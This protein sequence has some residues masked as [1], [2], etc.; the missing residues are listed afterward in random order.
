MQKYDVVI[1]GSGIG[2]LC[3]G[4]I[5]ALSG[6]KVLICEA[7][8]KPGGV[9]HSFNK[10]GY[11]FESGPSLW[12]GISKWPTTNPLGQIL[13]LLDVEVELFKYKGWKVIVPE[14]NFDLDVGEEPFKQIVKNLRGEQSVK[15]W[16]SFISEIQPLSQI[17]NEIPLL[18]FSPE[19]TN[20]LDLLNLTSKI[21]PNIKQIP[22]INKG[23][24][25][26]VNKHLEDPFLRNWVDLLS[27]LISGMSMHDTNTAAMATL[28]NEWFEPNSYLEY[29]KG[30]SESIV[31]ALINGLKKNGGELIL[32]SKVKEINFN[33]NL[34][35]GVSLE[36]GSIYSC[37]SVVVNTDVWNLKKLIPNEVSKKWKPKAL[38]PDKCGSFLHLHLGFDADGLENLP[39]HAIHVDEWEKGITTERNIAVFSIPSVLDKN[40][41][42][43]GKHVLHGYT[44]ANEPWEIWEDL[45][46]KELAYRNLKEERCSIF[47][48]AVRKFIPDIDERTDLKMFGT[49]ITH[50]KFTHTHCGSYGPALSAAKGLFPSCK[51]PIKNLFTCG[52]STFPGIGIPAVSASG[53]YAAEK[54]IGKKEFK[55][56]LK[57]I[58][59]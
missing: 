50:K 58:N 32:S 19:S 42:P 36:N 18:S 2:G 26:L 47:L 39:I 38:N 41:A 52:A 15:E 12:S 9:A 33:K 30:G 7:H 3:C 27:F 24:G 43:K 23:F 49:P 54:I 20:F 59:L 21:L 4:S 5:L 51:T 6:K 14:G 25:N 44:P 34:A 55:T 31:K 16:E 8:S 28:F 1:V 13:K 11:T 22:K 10:N 57:T 46:P 53:A 29:P 48:N 35:T 17:I 56:L 40:L 45:N 37:E